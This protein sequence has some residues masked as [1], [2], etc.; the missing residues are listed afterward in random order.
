MNEETVTETAAATR[1]IAIGSAALVEG[2]GLIGFETHPDVQ[3]WEL[4]AILEKIASSPR[5]AMIFLESALAR[6]TCPILEQIRTQYARIVVVEVPT[7]NAPTDFHPEV[8]H[9]VTAVLGSGALET[10][11]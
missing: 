10:P 6:C 7:L 8:E 4:E 3:L 11:T 2:F 1:L 9:L 5:P